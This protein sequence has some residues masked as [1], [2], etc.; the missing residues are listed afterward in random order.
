MKK[1]NQ[2]KNSFYDIYTRFDVWKVSIISVLVV[3][4]VD[5]LDVFEGVLL[6]QKWLIIF[7]GI[8]ILCGIKIIEFNPLGLLKF[9]SVNSIDYILE[10]FRIFTLCYSIISFCYVWNYKLFI[11]GIFCLI[12]CLIEMY[13]MFIINQRMC[14]NDKFNIYDLKTLYEGT[15]KSN[16]RLIL[17]DENDV[18]YDLLERGNVIAA[19]NNVIKN[20]YPNKKFVI[21]LEGPWGCGK[22]T[23]LNNMK[24]FII[25][26]E[27]II[28]DDFDPWSYEDEKSLFRGMFDSIMKQIDINFSMRKV[29][30]FIDTYLNTLFYNSKYERQYTFLKTYYDSYTETNRI[31]NIINDYLKNNNKRILFV[32]D[33]IERTEKEN[34]IFLFKLINN[35]LGLEN[36]IYL[37]S[38]D[39]T[40]MRKIFAEDLNI[41]YDYLKKIIQLEVKVPNIDKN[42]FNDICETCIKNLI[43]SYKGQEIEEQDLRIIGQ[44]IGDLR[45]LKRY[46][47]SVISYQ[48][49]INDYLNCT[50]IFLLEII[51]QEKPELYNQIPKNK[52]FFVAYDTKLD[53]DIYLFNTESFNRD[54]KI[55]FDSFFEDVS[56]KYKKILR[57]LF[58][59]VDRYLNGENLRN[60]YSF[61]NDKAYKDSVLN[62]KVSNVRYFDLYF[63]ETK[64]EFILINQKVEDFINCINTKKNYKL[65]NNQ[66]IDMILLYRNWIQKFI[67]ELLELSLDKINKDK[68]YTLLK[69][70]YNNFNKYN[71]SLMFFELNAM[72]RAEVIMAELINSVSEKELIEF[73]STLENKN[74]N[75]YLMRKLIY[76]LENSNARN[77][78]TDKIIEKMN[79]IYTNILDK[80]ISNNINI[81]EKD[82]Y[83][84]NNLWGIYH[85]T[86][87][88]EVLRKEYIKSILNE[89]TVF[90]FLN[91]MVSRSLGERYG[92]TILDKNIEYFS[93][94]QEIEEILSQVKRE[95]TDDEKMLVDI[96]YNTEED[97]TIYL[98]FD[99]DFNV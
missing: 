28:I 16:G 29:N 50:E 20:C 33:N 59:Y 78:N 93:T 80:I 41:D 57:R 23:I 90:R 21:A 63:S 40:K 38:F 84:K 10:I 91:D 88:N 55:F 67:F 94:R 13:R 65:L 86:K 73:Q 46:L 35:I 36:T 25:K 72:S 43:K 11:C 76:W 52:S 32:I 5:F 48:Y 51:K 34:I 18:N 26:D 83:F 89:N 81:L 95:F 96:F 60:D 74:L 75:L 14:K 3:L 44:N 1:I 37:L 77:I 70:I 42:I 97:K 99:K 17:I 7:I 66:F 6:K 27:I 39:D 58:P 2:Y 54:G 49:N 56:E 31:T 68:R 30:E 9:K 82:M 79:E 53:K 4:S 98:D 24:N 19:L 22:T 15:I 61:R 71:N 8:A 12:I 45:E 87:E 47:N 85:G 62:K 92:Y 64:N 69:L